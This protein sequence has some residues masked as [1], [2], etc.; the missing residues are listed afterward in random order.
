M[1]IRDRSS[2]ALP[3]VRGLVAPSPGSNQDDFG[4][5]KHEKRHEIIGCIK[6][7]PCYKLYAVLR[8]LGE[9]MP[10]EVPGTPDPAD[11]GI[12]KRKWESLVSKWRAALRQVEEIVKRSDEGRISL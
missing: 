3:E 12:S 5:G 4:R 11:E 1:C 2:A 9:E 10:C 6:L 8:D 7:K